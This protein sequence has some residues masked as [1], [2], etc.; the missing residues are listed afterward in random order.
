MNSMVANNMYKLM[1]RDSHMIDLIIMLLFRAGDIMKRVKKTI[2]KI[3]TETVEYY[4]IQ[5]PHCK[6]YLQ[7]GFGKRTIRILCSY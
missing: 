3:K 4:E 5:C 7:G 1:T 6:T 2:P